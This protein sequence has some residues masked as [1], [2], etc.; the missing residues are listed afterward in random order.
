M[1]ASMCGISVSV[2]HCTITPA[3]ALQFAAKLQAIAERAAKKEER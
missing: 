3:R 2:D 1:R